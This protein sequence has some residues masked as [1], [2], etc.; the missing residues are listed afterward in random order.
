MSDQFSIFD[1]DTVLRHC[2]VLTAPSPLELSQNQSEYLDTKFICRDGI[3]NDVFYS[4]TAI[5]KKPEISEDKSESIESHSQKSARNSLHRA[6]SENP[7]PKSKRLK[8]QLQADDDDGFSTLKQEPWF[9]CDTVS[10]LSGDVDNHSR[11]VVPSGIFDRIQFLLTGFSSRSNLEI[12]KQVNFFE[13]NR[14]CFLALVAIVIIP[15]LHTLIS[16]G[17]AERCYRKSWRPLFG[18][19][20]E[21]SILRAAKKFC[22]KFYFSLPQGYMTYSWFFFL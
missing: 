5:S 4:L 21:S 7:L 13:D 14:C 9:D 16:G 6:R 2:T 17:E 10:N 8:K 18:I 20:L 11:S 22:M 12:Q 19:T 15:N 3:E 1:L